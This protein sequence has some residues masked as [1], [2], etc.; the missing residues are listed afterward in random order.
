[1]SAPSK[2][3]ARVSLLYG[4]QAYLREQRAAELTERI[5]GDAPRDFA[6]HRFDAEELLKGGGA[7]GSGERVDAFEEACATPPF[8]CERYLLRLD[9]A[10]H[11]KAPAR[12]VQALRRALA[13]LQVARTRF[14]GD[15]VW[16]LDEALLPAEPRG[17]RV[18]VA[19]W[20]A[21]VEPAPG[22]HAR[23]GLAATA[24]GQRF[25]VAEGDTRQVLDLRAF[26][27]ACL[28]GRIAFADEPAPAPPAA[29]GGA[30]A[31]RLQRLL[32]RVIAGPP[33]G[34]WLLLTST[35]AR[36][37]E[38]P[39]ALLQALKQHGA[40]EKFVTYEDYLPA[41]WVIAQ[42]AAL[43]LR[44]DRAGAI[45]LV[46]AIGNDLATLAQELEKLSLLFGEGARP[47]AAE[48]RAALHATS[49]GSLF[50][51]TERL[52]NRDL[53]GAL[54][55]FEPFLEDSPQ[56]HPMLIGVL[57]RYFRQLHQVQALARQ[58]VTGTDAATELKLPLFI[59]R[60]L[61]SQAARY[62]PA[63]LGRVLQALAWLD[64][65]AKRHGGL[66]G[67][68]FRDLLQAICSGSLRSRP[69]SS[70]WR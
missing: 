54:A 46:R 55:V 10:E 20:V 48:L 22:G 18:R 33:P 52:G 60:K 64:V 4:N 37:R 28:R 44:L 29:G 2:S 3:P 68:M 39:A 35:V 56:G 7:E 70:A 50:Q 31:E 1:M 45:A 17:V 66:T 16:A 21:S 62:A 6:L 12:G 13:E 32:E 14:E 36:E 65:A 15:D 34:C 69:F 25:L 47:G 59:A 11:V 24:E 49:R 9:R 51:I 27:R 61:T 41:E 23:I 43:G 57:A 67:V 26:L 40:I 42:A 58:G 38:L 53:S 5:L 19:D 63:E 30:P 8:L